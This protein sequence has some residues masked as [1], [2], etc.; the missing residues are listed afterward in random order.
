[1]KNVAMVFRVRE[2]M[3]KGGM[4]MLVELPEET[5]RENLPELSSRGIMLSF[6]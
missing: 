4:D 5:V 3:T 6:Y 1:M 2:R